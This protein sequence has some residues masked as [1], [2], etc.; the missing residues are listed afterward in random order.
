MFNNPLTPTNLLSSPYQ[1]G[2]LLFHGD[3]LYSPVLNHVKTINL[4]N[5]RTSILPFQT[6]NQIKILTIDPTGTI[7]VAVDMAGFGLVWNL[8]GMFL[9]AEYNWKG[10]VSTAQFSQDGRLFAVTQNH[11]FQ[12]YQCP[13]FW[14]TF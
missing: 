12:V 1:S 7:M 11:G 10:V 2:N 9:V 6:H 14:R 3:T 5:N 13:S 4:A 8:K